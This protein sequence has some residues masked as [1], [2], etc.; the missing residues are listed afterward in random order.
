MRG[1]RAR[2]LVALAVTV[3]LL[4]MSAPTCLCPRRRRKPVRSPIRRPPVRPRSPCGPE[5][6]CACATWTSIS[7]SW[8][9]PPV[10]FATPQ[11]RGDVLTLNLF[12]YQ[13][14]RWLP[15]RA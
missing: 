10:E 4:G 8:T 13:Y 2:L 14:R 6:W 5:R 9:A 3:A 15:R 7:G 1:V 11:G 12:S